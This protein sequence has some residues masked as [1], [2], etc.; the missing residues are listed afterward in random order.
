MEI[1]KKVNV[2]E[3]MLEKSQYSSLPSLQK[4]E[5]TQ[6]LL[7]EFLRLNLMGL[8]A[9]DIIKNSHLSHSVI[10]HH[11]EILAS[12][13]E[14]LK[15]ERG[16]TDV[17]HLNKIM[18]NLKESDIMDDHSDHH[19]SYNFDIIENPFGK[20]LRIQRIRESR[21]LAHTIR[22]GVIIPSYLIDTVI[23]TIA[24]IKE[25]H[26]NEDKQNQRH[27]VEYSLK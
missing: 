15:I 3:N 24:K 18:D 10:W 22:S 14:C 13:G 9:S 11:L 27:K 12:R 16:D 23:N 20:F 6:N 1:T 5:Y 2:P 4:E 19:F 25:N 26:L 17:Y 7:K 8:T 21:S